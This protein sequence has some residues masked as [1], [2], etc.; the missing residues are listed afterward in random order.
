MCV[1]IFF[2]SGLVLFGAWKNECKW[3]NVFAM[4]SW[5]WT[6]AQ[7]I[8]PN[9]IQWSISSDQVPAFVFFETHGWFA[10]ATVEPW[11][12]HHEILIDLFWDPSINGWWKILN[13]KNGEVE[14]PAIYSTISR[15]NWALLTWIGRIINWTASISRFWEGNETSGNFH[16]FEGW[17]EVILR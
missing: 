11:T 8:Q 10:T 2:W 3:K 12:W 7:A 9:R 17:M 14:I 13:Q 4:I 6:W 5:T 16:H 1:S 15:V